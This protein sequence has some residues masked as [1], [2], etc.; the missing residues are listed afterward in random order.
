MEKQFINENKYQKVKKGLIVAAIAVIVAAVTI[1]SVFLLAPGFSKLNEANNIVIPSDQ[2]IK[3]EQDTNDA[4]NAKAEADL[5][6]KYEVLT[7]PIQSQLTVLDRQDTQVLMSEGRSANYYALQDQE[8]ALDSQLSKINKQKSDE[9]STLSFS[10]TQS[11][12]ISKAEYESKKQRTQF[13]ATPYFMGGIMLILVGCGAGLNLLFMAF[14]RNILAFG[15]QS[16]VPVAKE[17]I[18]DV[19]PIIGKA[20]GEAAKAAAHGLSAASKDMG[21]AF[22]TIA[23]EV[24]KGIK[25]GFKE[26]KPKTKE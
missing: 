26:D 21:P 9:S 20:Y 19:A 23:K 22:G 11:Y 25:E 6:A 10:K 4:K 15:A 2:E 7:A 16:T 5:D 3:A 13:D 18:E 24:S 12:S 14:G 1:S 8:T 17:V